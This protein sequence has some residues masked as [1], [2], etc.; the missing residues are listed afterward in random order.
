LIKMT[1]DVSRKLAEDVHGYL[2]SRCK[3]LREENE[4]DTATKNTGY[5]LNHIEIKCKQWFNE[6]I[7]HF[8]DNSI[9]EN[10]EPEMSALQTSLWQL[11]VSTHSQKHIHEGSK[12]FEDL[13]PTLLEDSLSVC[14]E[15]LKECYADLL[16]IHVLNLDISKYLRILLNSLKVRNEDIESFTGVKSNMPS[17]TSKAIPI[18]FVRVIC[19]ILHSPIKDSD[20]APIKAE[21]ITKLT[22]DKG[23]DEDFSEKFEQGVLDLGWKTVKNINRSDNLKER[24]NIAVAALKTSDDKTESIELNL[25]KG[26]ETYFF[27]LNDSDNLS[28]FASALLIAYQC[29]FDQARQCVS[30]QLSGDYIESLRKQYDEIEERLS[31]LA[32]VGMLFTINSEKRRGKTRGRY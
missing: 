12:N 13:L 18:D 16:M 2:K 5:Y 25:K 11:Y 32:Q 29:Y 9:I 7:K 23:F 30:E 28:R 24:Y 31:G 3:K 19:A 1:D 14:K 26:V 21:E 20:T 4:Q 27:R 22:S 17:I 10:I 15:I 8:L 6:F